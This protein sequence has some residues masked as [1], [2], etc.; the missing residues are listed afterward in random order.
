MRLIIRSVGRQQTPVVEPVTLPAERPAAPAARADPAGFP[1]TG[2]GLLTRVAPFAVVAVLAEAS[3]ALPGGMPSALP[4]VISVLLLLAVVGAFWLPWQRLPSWMTVLVPL[5]YAASALFLILA[6]GPT[7]GVGLVI[8]MPLVWTTLFQRRWESFCIVGAI[9]VVEVITSLAPV[10]DSDAV[11]VRRVILFGLLGVMV[12]IATHGL[13]DRIRR[14]QEE[15]ARLQDSL[16]ELSLI[17]DRDRIA[18]DL[19]DKV[20]QRIFAAGMSLQGAA[21]M[22]GDPQVRRRVEASVGDLDHAVRLLR[23]AIFGLEHRLQGRGLRQDILTLCGEL[24]PVPE[25]SFSGPV[26]GALHPGTRAQLLDILRDALPVI[27]QRAVPARIGVTARDDSYLT[28]IEATFA[29]DA[30]ETGE[31]AVEFS[32]LRDRASEASIHID[33]GRIPGGT[34]FAWEVPLNQ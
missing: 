26:D 21:S 15:T 33:I 28:V 9:L 32:S 16:R 24:S 17:A 19:R 25:I 18:A 1:F 12:T 8:L 7:A 13:R 20:I 6:A 11:I 30:P 22:I 29:P 4:A 10:V 2:P 23:D 14:S 3:L 31:P 27:S 34:R 5:T